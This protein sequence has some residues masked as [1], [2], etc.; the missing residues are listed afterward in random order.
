MNTGLITLVRENVECSYCVCHRT[1]H[2]NLHLDGILPDFTNKL[3]K[4]IFF[5]IIYV[6]AQYIVIYIS[7]ASYR[8][9]LYCCI[10]RYKCIFQK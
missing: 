10:L 9:T 8:S 6:I 2:L 5:K 1:T 7:Y 3:T 4:A